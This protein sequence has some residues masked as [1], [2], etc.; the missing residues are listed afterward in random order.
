MPTHLTKIGATY[1][2][3]RIVPEHL[4]P[5]FLT[6]TGKPRVEFM[7]SLGTKDRRE[8]EEAA[9]FRAVQVDQLFREAEA[10][11]AA[12]RT[13][14]EAR[15]HARAEWEEFEAREDAAQL[16]FREAADEDDAMFT[17]APQRQA[18]IDRLNKPRAEMAPA[19]LAF[20]D[21]IPD[22]EFA[23]QEERQRRAAKI[24]TDWKKGEALA[25]EQFLAMLG[26]K[27]APEP[28]APAKGQTPLSLVVN[29]WAAEMK[30]KERTVTRT[31]NIVE[32]FEAVN[33]KLAVEAVTKHHVIAFKD[34]LLADPKQTPANINVMIPMLGT[35]LIYAMDKL[36][37]IDVNP[38]A[39]VRVADKRKAKE[40]RRA[41][42]EAE[43]QRIFACPIYAQDERPKAGGGEAAY[44]L[45]LLSLYTGARETEL[46]QL[47]PDDVVQET[48]RNAEDK[49]QKAWV[50][51]IVE[52]TE[53]GQHVKNEGSERRVPVH[54]D[55]IGLGFIK[56]V[57]Q[58]KAQKRERI[59][60]DI[61]P[62]SVGELM[63]NWSKWFGR[64]RRAKCGLLT[65]ATPFHSFRHTF[66]HYMRLAA[67]PS[68]VHNELTGHET[69]D[70]AD[71]YGGLSYPL[72][73]LVEGMQAYEVPGLILPQPPPAYR[74]R[75]PE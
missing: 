14:P 68:E 47:H 66:K 28:A 34:A 19:E 64:Y 35:V 12:A 58:T 1:Y 13:D 21:L 7:E 39:R 53:R 4:R 36:H 38:A 46:G 37:L 11:L 29:R 41:F 32:R 42:E 30:P 27:A 2:F 17:R 75:E 55:L 10:R 56:F 60:P 48:Y 8:G 31:R 43:L 16:M 62:N 22:E 59:F 5:L 61:A 51:R 70:V 18:I 50:I 25:A 20:R 54:A 3:R 65:K 71:S 40:K 57:Q 33:G 67:V 69:G 73:P 15:R 24:A 6:R 49:P 23:T 45:P 9:R 44:W 72:R 26:N 74:T 63:G 52:N